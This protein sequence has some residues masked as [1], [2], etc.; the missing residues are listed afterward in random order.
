MKEI[1][2]VISKYPFKL[3]ILVVILMARHQ[4]SLRVQ[5]DLKQRYFIKIPSR[6]EMLSIY[7]Y[8]CD[9]G[10]I[11]CEDETVERYCYPKDNQKVEDLIGE[12]KKRETELISELINENGNIIELSDEEEVNQLLK[13][14]RINEKSLRKEYKRKANRKVTKKKS[15]ENERKKVVKESE[16]EVLNKDEN[17]QE[18]DERDALAR[19]YSEKEVAEFMKEAEE[20]EVNET[21]EASQ[22]ETSD[23]WI[24][25]K[26]KKSR[27]ET[28]F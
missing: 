12:E 4:S 9:T 27:L 20:S 10:A 17:S 1:D 6:I 24:N 15:L 3:K 14:E 22:P 13:E 11:K 28:F 2:K 26:G 18:L 23:F 25:E 21:L 16:N 19:E 7:E 8:F 5:E